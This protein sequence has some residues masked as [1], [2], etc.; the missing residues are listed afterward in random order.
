MRYIDRIKERQELTGLDTLP[1]NFVL[2]MLN[3][4]N[5]RIKDAVLKTEEDYDVKLIL[6]KLDYL[7]NMLHENEK[8]KGENK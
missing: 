2:E 4:I 7:C 1:I 5:S 3:D 8:L 6:N